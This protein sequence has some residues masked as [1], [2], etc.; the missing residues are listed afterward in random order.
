MRHINAIDLQDLKK[1]DVFSFYDET[2]E[3]SKIHLT[4]ECFKLFINFMKEG[5][6][7][8]QT[9]TSVMSTVEQT[10]K[11]NDLFNQGF[12]M[13]KGVKD[14]SKGFMVSPNAK[15]RETAVK[16]NN[17][18]NLYGDMYN[19][20]QDTMIGIL[21]SVATDIKALGDEVMDLFEIR[22]YIETME[23]C[24]DEVSKLVLNRDKYRAENKAIV[25]NAREQLEFAYRGLENLIEGLIVVK[26]IEPYS[27][28]INHLN[29]VIKK[30]SF[31]NKKQTETKQDVEVC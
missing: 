19:T 5:L 13:W 11:I 2:N 28:F 12:N 9:A 7:K 10:H 24:Y 23:K 25:Q 30:H 3:I 22:E 31:L 21:K 18:I 14:L 17:I 26:G 1:S 15:I 20:R 29:E 27:D 16:I 8:Y 6:D 4:D